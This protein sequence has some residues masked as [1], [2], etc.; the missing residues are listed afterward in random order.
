LLE[1]NPERRLGCGPLG[2]EEIKRHAFFEGIDWLKLYNKEYNPPYNPNVV[3][4]PPFFIFFCF[5]CGLG[6]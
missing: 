6:I 2:A 3:R 4:S 5:S 1:R